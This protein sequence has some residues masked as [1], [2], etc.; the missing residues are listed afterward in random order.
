MEEAGKEVD[1]GQLAKLQVA[2]VLEQALHAVDLGANWMEKRGL[3]VLGLAKGR[4][5][6]PHDAERRPPEGLEE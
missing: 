6:W 3:V 2:L 5:V 4:S 1:L